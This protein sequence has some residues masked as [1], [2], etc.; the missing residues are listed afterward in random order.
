LLE[1]WDIGKVYF[2]CKKNTEKYAIQ[3]SI[4]WVN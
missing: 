2:I 1:W 3:A 4:L